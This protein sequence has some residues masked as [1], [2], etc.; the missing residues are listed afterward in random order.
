VKSIP[1]S[2]GVWK[3]ELPILEVQKSENLRTQW[4]VPLGDTT[5]APIAP[6]G[7]NN[8]DQQATESL[9]LSQ[10]NS[11]FHVAVRVGPQSTVPV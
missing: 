3:D 2:I 11:V 1:I 5:P 10:P 4:L 9:S 7:G 8:R 6:I